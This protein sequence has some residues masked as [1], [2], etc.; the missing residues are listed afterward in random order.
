MKI[1]KTTFPAI[2][3]LLFC[4][5]CFAQSK[6]SDNNLNKKVQ[7]IFEYDNTQNWE[8]L[9]NSFADTMKIFSLNGVPIINNPDT[10]IAFYKANYQK[11]PKEHSTI[12][13]TITIGNK[14]IIKEKITGHNDNVP[15]YDVLIFEFKENKITGAWIIFEK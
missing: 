13:Q 8:A 3:M 6:Q 1:T 14:I 12:E 7:Q 9:R 5:N 2:L 10:L 11:F 4:V 15:I